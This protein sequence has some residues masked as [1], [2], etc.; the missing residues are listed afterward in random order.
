MLTA[1]SVARSSAHFAVKF[2]GGALPA[3]L[4]SKLADQA[5][6]AAEESWPAI[7]KLLG[8]RKATPPTLHIHTDVAAFRKLEQTFAPNSLPHP[9]F[10]QLG[11]QE[12]HL[13][14]WPPL[15]QQALQVVGLPETTR[16]LVLRAGAQ[17]MAAQYSSAA[18][19]DPWLAEV[20]AYAVLESI[21]NPKHEFGRDPAYDS[22]RQR[23][24]FD[25]EQGQDRE[26]R[27]SFMDFSQ[28]TTAREI[29][30]QE[31]LKC[32]MSQMMATSKK[33]WAR[34]LLPKAS[35]RASK[36]GKTV[37]LALTRSKAVKAVFGKNWTKVESHF[38]TM[39]MKVQPVWRAGGPM[40]SRHELGMIAV[41]T[42]DA[43]A[44]CTARELP[45]EVPYAIRA[46]CK[47]H[48]CGDTAFRVQLDW[49]QETMIGCFFGVGEVSVKR[50]LAGTSSWEELAKG[51]APIRAGLSFEAAVEVTDTVRLLVNGHEYAKWDRGSRPMNRMWSVGI[52]DCVLW[53]ENLRIESLPN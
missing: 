38:S 8:M 2:D 26:L 4:T 49:D 40:F 16:Q 19:G 20:F 25:L 10:V 34:K 7:S 21:V 52:N 22:R 29:N 37:P 18:A 23:L 42:K 6:A 28:P 44:S 48:P 13:L 33:G 31:E 50:W 35:K 11:E 1:Q 12:A 47:V 17:L 41:G 53:I 39:C 14:L 15:S 27:G 51:K 45:G 3:A 32:I 43:P 46:K 24:S 5:V 36:R 30:E 9:L